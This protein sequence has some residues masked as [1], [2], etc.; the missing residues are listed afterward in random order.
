MDAGLACD[1]ATICDDFAARSAPSPEGDPRWQKELCDIDA[2]ATMTVNGSLNVG[3]PA[4]DAST[5]CYLQS[6][7]SSMLHHAVSLVGSFD[8]EFDLTYHGTSNGLVQVASVSVYKPDSDAMEQDDF[9]LLIAG[10][11]TAQLLV[12]NSVMG[13]ASNTLATS[14]SSAWVAL[15]K[16][17]HISFTG[18]VDPP[19]ATATATCDGVSR[20]LSQV[21]ASIPFGFAG[22]AV[23]NFGY[24]QFNNHAS[25]ARTLVYSN[26]VFEASP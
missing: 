18:D 2:G 17:C 20:R 11:A 26:L 10:D 14:G 7:R 8:L 5:K 15:D 3:Q 1:A 4:I 13:F 21:D 25:P 9:E 23:L 24:G 12:L 16:A 22:D 19:S 6:Y